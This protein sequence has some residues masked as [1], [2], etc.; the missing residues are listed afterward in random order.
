M[1]FKF[2]VLIQNGLFAG[3]A[4]SDE[5]MQQIVKAIANVLSLTV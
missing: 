2:V 4:L 3:W 5:T 1:L